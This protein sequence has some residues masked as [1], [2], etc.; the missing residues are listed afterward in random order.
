MQPAF[1]SVKNY[2]GI[3]TMALAFRCFPD[4]RRGAW[5]VSDDILRIKKSPAGNSKHIELSQESFLS[6]G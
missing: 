5:G 4:H 3:E 6:I 1:E 2:I